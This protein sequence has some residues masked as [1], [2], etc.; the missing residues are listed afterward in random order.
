MLNCSGRDSKCCHRTSSNVLATNSLSPSRDCSCCQSGTRCGKSLGRA[1]SAKISDPKSGKRG[2]SSAVARSATHSHP[3]SRRKAPPSRAPANGVPP[4]ARQLESSLFARWSPRA[5]RQ[6]PN[7]C[8]IS[9]GTPIHQ[10]AN[11]LSHTLSHA[12]SAPSWLDSALFD[13]V[14]CTSCRLRCTNSSRLSSSIAAVSTASALASASAWASSSP[15]G[16]GGSHRCRC[17]CR[18]HS[19]LT[20]SGAGPIRTPW[21]TATVADNTRGKN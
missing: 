5:P 14:A 11:L 3:C 21:Q 15:S 16:W 13:L 20:G 1:G 4:A 2:R 8:C 17:R 18:G 12:A 6:L 9:G 19:Y 7:C 10:H